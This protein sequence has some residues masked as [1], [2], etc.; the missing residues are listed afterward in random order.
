MDG[1]DRMKCVF[2]FNHKW[3]I[4]HVMETEVSTDLGGRY[5]KMTYLQKCV[6]CGTLRHKRLRV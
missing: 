2:W 3:V 1:M 6:N 4:K 5:H